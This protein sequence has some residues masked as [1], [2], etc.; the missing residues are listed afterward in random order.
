MLGQITRRQSPHIEDTTETVDAKR[1]DGAR[2][3][4]SSR[5]RSPL[6]PRPTYTRMKPLAELSFA[7]CP[8]GHVIAQGIGPA[9][10]PSFAGRPRGHVIGHGIGGPPAPSFAGCPR[11]HVVAQGIG[12]S[13]APSF[14]GRPRGHVIGRR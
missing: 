13:P 1:R 9:P 2:H 8:R 10:A 12:R 11:G 4:R 5:S 14:A 7:G 3:R 6:P